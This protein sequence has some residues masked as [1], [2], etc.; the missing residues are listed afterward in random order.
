MKNY[1]FVLYDLEDN[2]KC[3][4]DNLNELMKWCPI[5][6]SDIAWKF[7]SSKYEYIKIIDYNKFYKLY[8]YTDNDLKDI[9]I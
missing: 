3:Y 7:N 5:R 4:F 2:F 8:A 9:F 1:F 6:R